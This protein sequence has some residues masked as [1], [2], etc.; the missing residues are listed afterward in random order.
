M[1]LGLVPR[2]L[3]MPKNSTITRNGTDPRL[4]LH[5][6]AYLVEYAR[7]KVVQSVDFLLMLGG[8]VWQLVGLITR[9]S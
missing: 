9:R 8:A 6:P 4:F 7:Q 1:D 3:A 5:N 2:P